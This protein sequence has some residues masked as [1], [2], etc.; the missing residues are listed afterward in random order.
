MRLTGASADEALAE[1]L[2]RLARLLTQ[3]RT[4]RRRREE[5]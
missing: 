3:R 5:A 2:D 4:Y 1:V